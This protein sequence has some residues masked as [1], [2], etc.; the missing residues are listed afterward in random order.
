MEEEYT[1]VKAVLATH[2]GERDMEEY[3]LIPRTQRAEKKFG[4]WLQ[5]CIMLGYVH[6]TAKIWRLWHPEINSVLQAWDVSFDEEK[7]VS[8]ITSDE[9]STDVMKAVMPEGAGS[10]WDDEED[11]ICHKQ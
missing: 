10:V 4:R 6:D 2:L 1:T 3:K 9:R 5:E 7:I 8:V 11:T